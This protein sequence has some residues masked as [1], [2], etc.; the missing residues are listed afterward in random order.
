MD[1]RTTDWHK[2]RA[3]GIGASEAAAIMGV[4]PYMTIV[5]LYEQKVGLKPGFKGNWA[6]ERG[7]LLEPK[8]RAD[9]ELRHEIEAPPALVVHSK[10]DYLRASLDGYN[11]ER[12]I[13]LEIKCPGEKDHKLALE[14]KVPVHYY[15]QVQHQL[16][17]TAAQIGHY[18][19]FKGERGV[20]VEV[21]PDWDYMQELLRKEIEFWLENVCKRLS[22]QLPA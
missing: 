5:D 18:Y 20:L 1:Q 19:S 9:Y 4:S 14:G 7:N 12:G 10:Y 15:P 21:K 22:P 6:T 8:A 16:M 13:V 17:V 3:L 11:P 2:W